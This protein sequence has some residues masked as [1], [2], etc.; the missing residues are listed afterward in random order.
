MGGTD[1]ET[2]TAVAAAEVRPV[3]TIR[4]K[5]FRNI[6]VKDMQQHPNRR[7]LKQQATS[8]PSLKIWVPTA[9][10]KMQTRLNLADKF[11][12]TGVLLLHFTLDLSLD[13]PSKTAVA[14]KDS[15]ICS[16]AV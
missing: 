10:I 14:N 1:T 11:T 5:T 9:E 7:N 8:Q 13:L 16:L 15:C 6:A 2:T 12:Q 4:H 3:R